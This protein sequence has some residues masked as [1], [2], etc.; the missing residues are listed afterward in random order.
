M[1]TL[2]AP[3]RASQH[4]ATTT[5]DM[6]ILYVVPEDS[7][8]VLLAVTCDCYDSLV[9]YKILRV[10]V[11]FSVPLPGEMVLLFC[12]FEACTSFETSFWCIAAERVCERQIQ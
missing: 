7:H 12:L 4:A 2:S 10:S 9:D 5:A 3:G 8:T 11:C 6:V 1:L